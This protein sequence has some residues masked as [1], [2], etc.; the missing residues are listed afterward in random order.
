MKVSRKMDPYN[1]HAQILQNWFSPAFPIGAFSYS[2]GLETAIHEGVVSDWQTLRSWISYLLKHG[3]AHNDIIFIK[4]AYEREDVNTLCL[5]LSAGWE[6]HQETKELGRAFA[7]I[8]R[9][10][11]ELN[12]PDGLAYPVAV[13]MAAQQMGINLRK[14][15]LAY[16]Q[17]FCANVI[18]VAVR[19]VPIG[20]IEGQLCLMDL[21]HS[22]EEVCEAGLQK[23]LSE[24]GGFA[25][26]SDIYSLKHEMAE[27]RIYRT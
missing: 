12:V 14:T 20:Q 22:I 3:S 10:T 7:S 17:G 25:L 2:H 5:S 13:G 23:S 16:L 6:R 11:C 24:L 27:Q 19:S 15:L 4:A 26:A 1:R 8:V 9:Q 21:M 18:S